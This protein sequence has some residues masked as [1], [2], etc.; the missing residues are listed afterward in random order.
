MASSVPPQVLLGLP[1]TWS[2]AQVFGTGPVF[3]DTGL[4][5][6]F[7]VALA[8]DPSV[9]MTPAYARRNMFYTTLTYSASTS[10]IWEG[11]CVFTTISGPG[12][13]L[14][15]INGLHTNMTIE[16]GATV[17]GGECFEGKMQNFGTVNTQWDVFLAISENDATG[18]APGILRGFHA[19]GTNANAATNAVANYTA[20]FVDQFLGTLPE[21]YWA[22]RSTDAASM[23]SHAGI[24]IFGT[25]G[26]ATVGNIV[27]INNVSAGTNPIVVKNAGG[28]NVFYIQ[29]GGN[30]ILGGFNFDGVGNLSAVNSI[31][32]GSTGIIVA[33]TG[34]KLSFFQGTPVVK[35]TV[36]G[37]K[38]SNAAVAS[39]MAA[40]SGLGLVTDSTT[41]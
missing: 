11:L 33:K 39:L 24:A 30:G 10:N 9:T 23:F 12:T 40:L 22:F 18:V 36:T 35:P 31:D 14:G 37:A 16:A 4:P 34:S 38:A 1:S 26:P 19:Y 5:S 8:A 15:E 25:N 41:T 2:A 3:T 17:T 21:F 7:Q 28:T 20:F 32:N 29:N 27:Q 13:A 6:N